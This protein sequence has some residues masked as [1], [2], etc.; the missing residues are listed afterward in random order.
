M[1]VPLGGE[2]AVGLLI[3]CAECGEAG[4]I[5][6]ATCPKCGSGDVDVTVAGDEPPRSREE[7][8]GRYVLDRAENGEAGPAR[9]LLGHDALGR[10]LSNFERAS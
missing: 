7:V 8:I 3:E 2:D 1:S 6:V 4:K 10:R 9:E 5:P